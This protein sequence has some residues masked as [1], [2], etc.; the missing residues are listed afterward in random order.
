MELNK[1][2]EAKPES[3]RVGSREVGAKKPVKQKSGLEVRTGRRV[4]DPADTIA[5]IETFTALVGNSEQALQAS[6]KVGGLGDVGLSLGIL[7]TQDEHGRRGRDVGK[8]GRSVLRRELDALT[9][10]ASILG[11]EQAG[12]N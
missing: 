1:W 6:A 3:L 5:Q 2:G 9:Q 11:Y 10:H 4:L 8:D 12:K 7:S